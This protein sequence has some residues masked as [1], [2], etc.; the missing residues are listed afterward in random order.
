MSG[1]APKMTFTSATNG[2]MSDYKRMY[3]QPSGSS[4]KGG[5]A[6]GP[7]N[8]SGVVV[9]TSVKGMTGK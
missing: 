9:P 4:Y 2:I 1:K 3:L 7:N 8:M 6:I 5:K